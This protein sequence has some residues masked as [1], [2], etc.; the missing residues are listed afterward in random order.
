[1]KKGV[2]FLYL[3]F[4]LTAVTLTACSDSQS[5]SEILLSEQTER[6][7]EFSETE[8]SGK[9]SDDSNL[10]VY[11]C[12]AVKRPDVYELPDG[13]RVNDA[14]KRAG[15]FTKKADRLK[16][17]LAK[18]LSDGEQ[19]YIPRKGE[20]STSEQPVE[21]SGQSQKVNINLATKEELMTLTGIGEAKADS[22][23]AYREEHGAFQSIEELKEIRGI[24]DGVFQ[25]V[26]DWITIH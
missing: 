19:I 14:V 11:V 20:E 18:L 26:K 5:E 13:A 23:L 22:I 4:F 10:Y 21:E 9:T 6:T 12:G 8:V 7:T 17:N 24:K 1:M 3:F 16:V 2:L 25:K 15:G